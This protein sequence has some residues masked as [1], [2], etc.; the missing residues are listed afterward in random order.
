V[1]IHQFIQRARKVAKKADQA[2]KE[3]GLALSLVLRDA[4]RAIRDVVDESTPSRPKTILRGVRANKAR[5]E[6]RNALTGAGYDDLMA[7]ATGEPLDMV[8]EAVLELRRGQ[9]A[10]RAAETLTKQVESL[11]AL[12]LRELLDEGD[13]LARELWKATVRGIFATRSTRDILADLA[14]VIDRTEPQIRTLY[15]TS[16]SIFGRQVEALQAGDDDE[17]AF[18]YL[19]PD[20]E[21]TREFCQDHVGKVYTRAEIDDLDNGQLDNVFLTGG[22]YNC[23]HQW[24]EVAKSS[25]LMDLVGTG[26]RIPE[27]EAA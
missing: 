7:Q 4:E 12:N 20:D 8:A 3:F 13:D 6:I 2:S 15:D 21:K 5:L 14:R 22:G 11:K 18:L 10:I 16:V 1:T 27:L 25:E 23:R 9:D 19:G 26:E 24:I 17:T